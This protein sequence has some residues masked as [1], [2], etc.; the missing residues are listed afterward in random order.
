LLSGNRGLAIGQ[1]LTAAAT[2]A[3]VIAAT[4]VSAAATQNYDN[5]NDNPATVV[6]TKKVITH[7]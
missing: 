1:I 6:A 7:I 4:V 3:I 2:T 5:E